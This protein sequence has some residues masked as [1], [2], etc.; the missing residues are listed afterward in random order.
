MFCDPEI[1][2]VNI[3][4]E[5]SQNILLSRGSSKYVIYYKK[6]TKKTRR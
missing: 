2:D 4:V 6:K 3:V 1:C 5:G